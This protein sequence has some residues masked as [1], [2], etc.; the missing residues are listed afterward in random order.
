MYSRKLSIFCSSKQLEHSYVEV[1]RQG[2]NEFKRP[3]VGGPHR[4]FLDV[5]RFCTKYVVVQKPWL[6]TSLAVNPTIKTGLD[7]VAW[8]IYGQFLLDG[9]GCH[10]RHKKK[11]VQ[12]LTSRARTSATQYQRTLKLVLTSLRAVGRDFVPCRARN[13]RRWY[14]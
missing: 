13:H 1:W 4:Q 8:P 2:H 11:N 12:A 9:S 10:S 7:I 6:R 3:C 14:M 5:D